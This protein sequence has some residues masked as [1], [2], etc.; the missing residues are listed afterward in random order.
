MKPIHLM[1]VLG[2]TAAILAADSDTAPLGEPAKPLTVKEWVQGGP[3]NLSEG[4]GRNV[5]VLEF[6]ATW[7]PPCRESI[8]HLSE[9]HAQYK[10][11]GLVIVGITDEESEVVRA[12]VKKQGENLNYVIAIDDELRTASDYMGV[13]GLDSIPAAFVVDREG[14]VAWYGHPLDPD[15]EKK[16]VEALKT[17]DDSRKSSRSDTH[18]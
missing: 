6:W 1:L 18:E 10:D 16:I 13:F 2:L 7:C 3:V 14:R 4:K 15:F 5:Y 8:P 11:R 12:F 17:N 9:L